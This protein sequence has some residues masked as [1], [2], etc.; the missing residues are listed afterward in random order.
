MGSESRSDFFS[1]GD[2]QSYQRFTFSWNLSGDNQWVGILSLNKKLDSLD[3]SNKRLG[4]STGNTT[5][6]KISEKLESVELLSVGNN[7][8]LRGSDESGWL[9]LLVGLQKALQSTRCVE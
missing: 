1:T 6:S 5:S 3:W 4:D 9:N 8:L 7:R 2:F